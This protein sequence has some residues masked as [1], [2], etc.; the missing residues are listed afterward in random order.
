MRGLRAVARL[1]LIAAIAI[2]G[3]VAALPDRAA[4]HGADRMHDAGPAKLLGGNIKYA[5]AQIVPA[6]T[7]P[8]ALP[9]AFAGTA[10][11]HGDKVPVAYCLVVLSYSSTRAPR[12]DAAE[13]H[14]LCRSSAQFGSTAASPARRLIRPSTSRRCKATGTAAPRVKAA[15]VAPAT[16]TSIRRAP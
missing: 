8:S 6:N 15:V 14:H 13:H 9:G 12:S 3:G 10:P 4:A 2:A 11:E 16:P 7:S 5:D 1:S